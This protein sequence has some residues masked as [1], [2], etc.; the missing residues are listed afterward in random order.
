MTEYIKSF[1]LLKLLGTV[2]YIYHRIF[3]RAINIVMDSVILDQLNNLEKEV[4]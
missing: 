1:L 3:L 2:Y 4:D